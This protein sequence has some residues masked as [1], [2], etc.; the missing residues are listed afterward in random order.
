MSDL[1]D[2]RNEAV[3]HAIEAIRRI[4]AEDGV[5]RPALERIRGELVR[6]AERAELF[7]ADSFPLEPD[8][9]S[10][11]Y[12][13]SEDADNRFALY[14]SA[15]VAGKDTPPHDHTT[16]AVIAGLRGKEHNRLY[17]RVDDG[18]NPGRGEVRHVDT[19][20]V[21]RGSGVCLMP[22]DIH[23]IHLEGDPPTLMFHMYGMGLGNL[24]DRIYFDRNSGEV[25]HFDVT[26]DI[27]DTV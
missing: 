23:S 12:R 24:P 16:W 17:R 1:A 6:L 3:S 10:R 18:S 5:T 19:V 20:I 25:K 14:M 26:P 2:D 7:P 15:G 11:I 9:R 4:E 13:L 21:E 27:V 22:D 8:V